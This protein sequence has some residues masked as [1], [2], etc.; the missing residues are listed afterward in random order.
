MKI[1]QLN[2]SIELPISKEEA[3]SFLSDPGNLQKLMPKDMGF[4]IIS[5]ADRKAYAGQL[6]EYNVVPFKGFKTKW[7]TEITH[8]QKPDYFVDIQLYGPYKLWH[9]KH[10]IHEIEGGVRIEDIVHY[11]VPFGFLGRLMHPV[12]VKPKLEEIFKIRTEKM[13]ALFGIYKSNK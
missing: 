9:H 12:V 5:G 8:V 7:V 6:I 13:H 2:K 11:R 3:W 1:Y 10:F 4:D